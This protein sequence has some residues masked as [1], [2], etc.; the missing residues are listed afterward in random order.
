MLRVCGLGNLRVDGERISKED[1]AVSCLG[2]ADA[3]GCWRV[4]YICR[5]LDVGNVRPH[6][7]NAG[8]I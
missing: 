7:S 6:H 2:N 3:W 8:W 5:D 4:N 1:D